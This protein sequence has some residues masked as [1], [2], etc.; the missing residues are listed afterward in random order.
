MIRLAAK[1]ERKLRIVVPDSLHERRAKARGLSPAQ[2]GPVSNTV[3]VRLR[4]GRPSL[5]K[6]V[7]TRCWRP[8]GNRPSRPGI[9]RGGPAYLITS[10]PPPRLRVLGAP[11]DLLVLVGGPSARRRTSACARG[12]GCPG[13]R[14]AHLPSHPELGTLADAGSPPCPRPRCPTVGGLTDGA[15]QSV[16]CGGTRRPATG[17]SVRTIPAVARAWRTTPSGTL[18]RRRGPRGNARAGRTPRGPGAAPLGARGSS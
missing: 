3:E 6:A 9:W 16:P 10:S 13:T 1:S 14:S 4:P 17:S 7:T 11:V 5:G 2:R 8:S 12:W 18:P 15:S